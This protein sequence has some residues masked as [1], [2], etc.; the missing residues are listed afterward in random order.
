M[1]L[2]TI[3]SNII[4]NAVEELK[5]QE[6]K[7]K[8]IKVIVKQGRHFVS[9]KV[10]NSS[11]YMWNEKNETRKKDKRNHGFGLENVKE[12]IGRNGGEISFLADGKEVSVEVILPL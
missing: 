7:E 3:F 10:A 8:Y 1:E 4:Q 12:A 5:R 2:C 6:K 11:D 9:V